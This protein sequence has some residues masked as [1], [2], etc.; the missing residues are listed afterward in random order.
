MV[1]AIKVINSLGIK[2]QLTP[3]GT[4]LELNSIDE[5]AKLINVLS[6]KFRSM[7]VPRLVIDLSLDLRYD[8]EITLEYKV[9]SVHQKL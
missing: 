5:A 8:K 1:E 6:E 9:S 3:F 2:H 7:G 4:A